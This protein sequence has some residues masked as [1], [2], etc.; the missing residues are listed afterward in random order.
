[1]D[2]QKKQK[3]LIVVLAVLALGAG[4]YYFVLRDPASSNVQAKQSGPAQRRQRAKT[5]DSGRRDKK[6]SRK[7]SRDK[8]PI[9]N[10]VQKRDRKRDDTKRAERRQRR[11][12]KRTKTKKKE[13]APAA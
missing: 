5:A 12:G 9:V 7:K 6:V 8:S 2:E 11:G 13:V 10:I 3:V 4:G 1:M